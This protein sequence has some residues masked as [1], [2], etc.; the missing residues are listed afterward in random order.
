MGVGS[1][2]YMYDVV[3]K[4]SRSLSHLLMSSCGAKSSRERKPK[5]IPHRQYDFYSNLTETMRPSRT[6]FEILSLIFQKL[7]RSRDS[8]HAPFKDN[9]SN[10]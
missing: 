2:L 10:V 4:R 7:K 9:L 6:V 5:S 3:E 1:G 8:E